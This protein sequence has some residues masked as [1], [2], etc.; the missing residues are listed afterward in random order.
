M[1]RHEKL[2]DE[3]TKSYFDSIATSH[4]INAAANAD[5]YEV[6]RR[7]LN[8]SDTHPRLLECGGG[9]GFYTRRFLRDGYSVSCIDLSDQA[10]EENRQQAERLGAAERL[11]TIV[12]DFTTEALAH[13]G[14]FDQVVFI[15]VLHHFTSL[16]TIDHAIAAGLS[17]CRPGGRMVIFEPN[18]RNFLWKFFLSLARDESTGKTKWFYEQNLRLTTAA[19]LSAILANHGVQTA[20]VQY[21]YVLPAFI[22]E[23]RFP[24]MG[25]LRMLN[26]LL[27][28][29]PFKR[30]AFNIAF[31]LDV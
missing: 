10:L 26:R 28:R 31:A 13:A 27:E 16:E 9:G 3:H 25:L 22:I 15:K 17:A 5:K 6:V 19:N 12:G 21:R 1:T 2:T 18:G 29:S 24:G 20:K 30:L 23:K 4:G 8:G 7:L 14:G 11:T